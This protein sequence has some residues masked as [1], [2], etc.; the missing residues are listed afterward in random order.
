MA[1]TSSAIAASQS[2]INFRAPLLAHVII[3]MFLKNI[4]KCIYVYIS[5]LHIALMK[6]TTK[7]HQITSRLEDS[8]K[9]HFVYKLTQSQT[10]NTGLKTCIL[11]LYSSTKLMC[12]ENIPSPSD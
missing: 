2:S 9:G 8:D 3:I 10:Y 11:K 4:L 1:A 6:E 7:L 5:L 12:A